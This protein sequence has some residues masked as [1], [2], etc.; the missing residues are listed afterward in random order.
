MYEYVHIVH[1]ISGERIGDPIVT[2]Q[3]TSSIS[4]DQLVDEKAPCRVGVLL[5]FAGVLLFFAGY[6]CFVSVCE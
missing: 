6:C 5:F 1:R 4:M 2:L 3:P